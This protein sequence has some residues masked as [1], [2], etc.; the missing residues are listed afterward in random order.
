MAAAT[1]AS[2]A[3]PKGAIMGLGNPLLDISA[4]TSMDIVDK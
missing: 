4:E 1:T 2:A 3:V